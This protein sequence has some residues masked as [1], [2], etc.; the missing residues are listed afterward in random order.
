MS[1][2]YF[3][4]MLSVYSEIISSVY[5]KDFTNVR[6]YRLSS[7]QI[8]SQNDILYSQASR[9]IRQP[10]IHHHPPTYAKKESKSI[11]F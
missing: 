6:L 8:C 10:L 9:Q 7:Y 1:L 3:K 5:S 11:G 2:E 4:I